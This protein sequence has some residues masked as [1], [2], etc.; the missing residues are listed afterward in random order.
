[1]RSKAKFAPQSVPQEARMIRIRILAGLFLVSFLAAVPV[2]A[3]LGKTIIV[4]A[5]SEVDH[6]LNEISAATDPAAKFKLIDAF[7]S[8]HPVAVLQILAGEQ[9]VN[10]YLTSEQ[11]D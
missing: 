4:S 10:Y 3:Q 11:Y 8:A 2:R 9:Y 1:M 6:Q 5:G 7:C